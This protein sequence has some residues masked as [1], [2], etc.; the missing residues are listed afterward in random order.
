VVVQFQGSIKENEYAL[1]DLQFAILRKVAVSLSGPHSVA[2]RTVVVSQAE[3]R[4]RCNAACDGDDD[5]VA[6]VPTTSSK[7]IHPHDNRSGCD[8]G[9]RDHAGCSDDLSWN[10]IDSEVCQICSI[11]KDDDQVVICDNCHNG[12]H[13][14]CVKP[15]MVIIPKGDWFC[16]TCAS[17]SKSRLSFDEFSASITDQEMFRFLGLP[18]KTADEFFTTHSNAIFL[19]SLNSLATVK[20]YA[21]S[22]GIP[23][24]HP[25]IGLQNIN[26]NQNVDEYDWRLPM[27]LT[28]EKIY[29]SCCKNPVSHIIR[30]VSSGS[31]NKI[32]VFC[33]CSFQR[34]SLSSIVAAMKSCEM[35]S[36]LNDLTYGG[37]AEESMNDPSMETSAIKPMRGRNLDVF[38]AFQHNLKEGVF[39]P[40]QIVR[41]ENF[42]LSVKALTQMKQHTLIAQYLGEVI[43][44]EDSESQSSSDSLMILLDSGNPLTS[45][46]ID[47]SREGNFARF[48][49]GINN[50]N[51]ESKR[52]MNVRSLRFVMDGKLRVCLFTSRCVKAGELL[53]YDYNAGHKGKDIREWTKTGFYDTS[54]FD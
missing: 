12:F 36:Y 43:T 28:D 45:L 4:K 10:S 25:V 34:L 53:H 8:V 27:P 37:S 29:V 46:I 33:C 16:S 14:Y 5:G 18:Y 48:L 41:D 6:K 44:M 19:S 40:I 15:V 30:S 9:M 22:K 7:I 38:R 2:E 39:P 35:Q 3:P 50:G 23:A 52:R 42:G 47:P 49:G 11:D 1:V 17:R 20:D 26:F 24:K 32:P 31:F 21:K 13:M 51:E 54:N